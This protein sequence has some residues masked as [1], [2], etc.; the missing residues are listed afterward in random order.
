MEI[1]K[2]VITLLAIILVIGASLT[3]VGCI[4]NANESSKSEESQISE[5]HE[6]FPDKVANKLG[7]S[8]DQLQSALTDARTEML[9][10]ATS[11]GTITQ[12]QTDQMKQRLEKNS[13]LPAFGKRGFGPKGMRGE[14]DPAQFEERLATAVESGR[15]TQE[16]ADQIKQRME[17]HGGLPAFGKRGFG[18]P[19]FR[20][21]PGGN[22]GQQQHLEGKGGPGL[23]PGG[24][25][26]RRGPGGRLGGWRR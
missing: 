4:D 12:E 20:G 9:D 8:V 7:V 18:M 23:G 15:I 26:F 25:P 21:G 22:F 13:G 14:H 16:Q 11:E 17:E 10:E 19:P 1:R 5:D 2:K 3:T 6:K 24:S